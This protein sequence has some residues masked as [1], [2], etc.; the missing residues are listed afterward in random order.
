MSATYPSTPFARRAVALGAAGG[1]TESLGGIAV[2][3]LSI[4]AL[5][6]V[7]PGLLTPIAGIVFG[8][9][10]IVEGAALATRLTAIAR[11]EGA[12]LLDVGGGVTV[13]LVSGLAAIVLGILALIGIAPAVLTAALVITGGVGLILSMGVV[14]QLMVGA[15]AVSSAAAAHLMAGLGAV[16]LGIVALARPDVL[17]VLSTIGLLVLGASLTLSGTSLSSILLRLFQPPQA[18]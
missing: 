14:N 13:E 16:V 2:V 12:Q 17:A 3:I 11:A 6:R 4:L 8:I 10:F 18:S 15:P 7:L 1:T 9:A 5:V